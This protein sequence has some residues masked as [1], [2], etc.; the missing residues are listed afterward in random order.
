[1]FIEPPLVPVLTQ[2]NMDSI[3]HNISFFKPILILSSHSRLGPDIGLLP[4][5]L[6]TINEI[7]GVNYMDRHFRFLIYSKRNNPYI[8]Y[9]PMIFIHVYRIHK[10]S[11]T[12]WV[13]KI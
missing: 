3:C 12:L 6:S 8:T 5:A 13:L 2:I 4:F 10:A 9:V 1:M 7:S 11:V